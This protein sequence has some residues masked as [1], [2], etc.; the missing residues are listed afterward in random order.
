MLYKILIDIFKKYI[1]MVS[2]DELKEIDIKNGACYYFDDIIR[3]W[4]RDIDFSDILLYEKLYKEKYKKTLTY[5]ISYE[6][7]MGA[8]SSGIRF[9][10]IDRFIKIHD[11]IRYLLLFDYSCCDKICDKIKYVISEKSGIIILQESELIHMILC[12]LKKYWLFILW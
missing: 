7:S 8:K 2:K 3:F 5:D 4:D 9:N 1:E 10:E 11:K 6:I 12:L